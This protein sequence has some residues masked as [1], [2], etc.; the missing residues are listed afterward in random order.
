MTGQWLFC[1]KGGVEPQSETVWR[2]ANKYKVPRI[3][4]IN[5]M[6][7]NGADFFNVMEMMRTRLHTKPV[8]ITLP[9]GSEDTFEEHN[10]CY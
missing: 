1:A 9:I 5:K 6:D 8:A 2:Q 7:I 4:F 10:R 3:A